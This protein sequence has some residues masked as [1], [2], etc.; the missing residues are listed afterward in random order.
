MLNLELMGNEAL[1]YFPFRASANF[2]SYLVRNPAELFY[3]LGLN[4]D[5]AYVDQID[6]LRPG[7]CGRGW[8]AT[9]RYLTEIRR[10]ASEYGACL[11]FVHVPLK[12]ELVRL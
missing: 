6:C 2:L 4:D 1:S 12:D 10:E 3:K 7:K 11:V 8:A 9:E 5:F